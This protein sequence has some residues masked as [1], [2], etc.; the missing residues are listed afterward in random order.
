MEGEQDFTTQ[1]SAYMQPLT[2]MTP[3]D[4]EDELEILRGAEALTHP[5]VQFQGIMSGVSGP[6]GLVTFPGGFPGS[7]QSGVYSGVGMPMRS[8]LCQGAGAIPRSGVTRSGRSYQ[9][10]LQPVMSVTE[11]TTAMAYGAGVAQ[12]ATPRFQ[13]G[14][15]PSSLEVGGVPHPNFQM[16]SLPFSSEAGGVTQSDNVRGNYPPPSSEARGIPQMATEPPT[17]SQTLE[18]MAQVMLRVVQLQEQNATQILKLQEQNSLLQ[19]QNTQLIGLLTKTV[20]K[21]NRPVLAPLNKYQLN[22]GESLEAYLE[23]FEE[24]CEATYAGSE[25]ERLRLLESHL[26]GELLEVYNSTIQISRDYTQVKLALLKWY[27]DTLQK[28]SQNKVEAFMS[29]T[30]LPN[31]SV[32]LFAMRL[33]NLA[34]RYQKNPEKKYLDVLRHRL[35]AG[36]PEPLRQESTKA[37]L[38]TEK[39]GGVPLTWEKVV[40]IVEAYAESGATAFAGLGALAEPAPTSMAQDSFYRSPK[41]A[42]PTMRGMYG[43]LPTM[44]NPTATKT[45]TSP[46]GEQP[47]AVSAAQEVVAA[48]PHPGVNT[49]AQAPVYTYA[50]VAAGMT[51]PWYGRAYQGQSRP[52]GPSQSVQAQAKKTKKSKKKGK[53]K[54]SSS[55]SSSTG[56]SSSGSD[57]KKSRPQKTDLRCDFCG[58]HGHRRN[59]CP[60]RTLCPYC[61]LRGHQLSECYA[62]QGKCFRCHQTGHLISACKQ[63]PASAQQLQQVKCP[64]CGGKHLGKDCR[65]PKKQ[66]A[67]PKKQSSGQPSKKPEKK[68]GN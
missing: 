48:F 44:T 1:A 24:F 32:G 68:Q 49:Q 41:F 52:A 25:K 53:S 2:C 59:M 23:Q 36:L 37:L 16:G 29:A 46:K 11:G 3:V 65:T 54:K 21:A 17:L 64:F 22:R 18:Q 60:S 43:Q 19:Q 58:K 62:A 39:T 13:V 4:S 45:T 5:Q 14:Q 26:E 67:A 33:V 63:P 12:D 38:I 51:P 47:R 61:G 27:N 57:G 42:D 10:G 8:D 9:L 7:T 34:K 66:S 55:E 20:V 6:A 31:E 40:S 15:P 50:Q 35:L 28:E 30:L 56:S